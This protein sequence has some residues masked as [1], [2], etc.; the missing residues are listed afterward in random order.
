MYWFSEYSV[1]P[2]RSSESRLSRKIPSRSAVAES[3]WLEIP[4]ILGD[5][6]TFPLSCCWSSL[7]FLYL[8]IISMSWRMLVTGFPVKDFL[9]L[10]S[11]GRPS[12]KVLMAT[13]L[14]SPSISLNISQYLSEYVFRVSPSFMDK[15]NKEAKDRETLLHVIK[16]DPNAWVSSL[17]ESMGLAL[18]PSNHLI[19]IGPKL[20]GN[21]LHIKASFLE[22]TAILWLKWLTCSTWFVLPL[23]IVNVSW[24]NRRGSLPPSIQHMK[25]DLEIW[26]SALLI[27]SF[28]RPTEECLWW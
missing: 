27:A 15:E 10:C 19:A 5:N 25:G 6:L 26:L 11:A 28:P 13:W 9:K 16:W 20:D 24:V 3:V 14:K 4:P 8:S 21:T 2:L 22:C 18:R 17:K 12:L 1:N 7:T 23:Y